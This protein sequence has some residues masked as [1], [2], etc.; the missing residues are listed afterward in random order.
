MTNETC[1]N[2]VHCWSYNHSD[3]DG[4]AR[5]EIDFDFLDENPMKQILDELR[6]KQLAKATYVS[7]GRSNG[8]TDALD[9]LAYAMKPLTKLH[10]P[11][12]IDDVRFND[13]A[14]IV[15]WSDGTKTVVK[16]QDDEPFD[17]EKGLAMAMVKKYLGNKG[18]YFNTISKWTEEYYK[19]Q[20]ILKDLEK[21]MEK[22][23]KHSSV[24][25]VSLENL[26]NEIKK[27]F[28]TKYPVVIENNS[29]MTLEEYKPMPSTITPMSMFVETGA[30]L[31][32]IIQ[33]VKSCIETDGYI[34]LN[35]YYNLGGYHAIQDPQN[36]KYDVSKYGW[37][38]LPTFGTTFD[39]DGF[40]LKASKAK[41]LKGE[42]E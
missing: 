6:G 28:G 25:G 23:S 12:A 20:D 7:A 5:S 22:M 31:I 34:P 21:E 17:P 42:N 14:T 30:D 1:P 24:A 2:R 8:K 29:Y 10:A 39:E 26:L 35:H 33:T 15:F 16:T 36:E 13:P 32:D 27:I 9:A 18:N 11:P 37:T 40:L 4:C 41:L 19:Q 38:E 3:C